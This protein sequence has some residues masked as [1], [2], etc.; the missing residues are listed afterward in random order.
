MDILRHRGAAWA[1]LA[2]AC[3]VS[4]ACPGDDPARD[5]VDA[6]DEGLPPP[7]AEAGADAAGEADADPGTD[8]SADVPGDADAAEA[9]DGDEDGP[10]PGVVHEYVGTDEAF[11]NPE[12]GFHRLVLINDE[13]DL[14]WVR[15]EGYVLVQG[16]SHLDTV[17]SA[18]IT[19]ELLAGLQRGL[20]A[21]RDAGLKIVLRFVYNDGFDE[22]ASRDWVLHHIGQLA[23]VW[24]AN[25][26]VIL[27]LQAGFVGAWGEWHSSTNHLLDDVATQR[28]IVDAELAALPSDR[29][30][31]L[32]TPLLKA[33]MFGATPLSEASAFD[34]SATARV[35]HHNDCFL[36]SDTDMGTYPDGEIEAWKTYLAQETR[37]VPMGGETCA[38]NPPRSEC[39]SALAEM[40]RLHVTYMHQGYHPDVVAGWTAGGCRPEIDRRLGYRFVLRRAEFPE[41][42]G[43]GRS[44][45]LR[46]VLDNEGW[47]APFNPRPVVL[48]LDDGTR[49][50]ELV[51][52]GVDPRRWAPGVETE[53]TAV[54]RVPDA[55]PAG[56]YRV[57]LWLPD[58]SASL[59]ARA[60]YAVRLADDGIWDATLGANVLG[61][62]TVE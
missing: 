43:A 57:L 48:V 33:G 41:T 55:L 26:D 56:S 61:V 20:D 34:G 24:Q 17:R 47:A 35:G 18:P 42:L 10:A 44:F 50:E 40:E 39:A 9:T 54:L 3:A 27:V 36:A 1:A 52:D 14:R 15:D 11:L 25:A 13:T 7:D 2:A 30:L 4:T 21:V 59:R 16:S 12:R 22:D 49:R 8:E 31:Q 62:L 45:R 37:F 5:V 29:M 28:T 46:L 60:E 58:A 6:A 19:T 51:L 53:V 32:R 23:P 38:T